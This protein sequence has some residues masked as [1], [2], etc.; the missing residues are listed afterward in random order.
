MTVVPCKLFRISK[1]C[2]PLSQ[3]LEFHSDE[4]VRATALKKLVNKILTVTTQELVA[5]EA[6]YHISCYIACTTRYTCAAKTNKSVIL[7]QLKILAYTRRT[8]VMKCCLIT[9][10]SMAA[11]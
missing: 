7:I 10:N 8:K 4:T 2:E 3:S 6:K 1:T 11:T 5:A 9:M